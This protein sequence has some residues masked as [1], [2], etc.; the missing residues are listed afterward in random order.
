MSHLGNLASLKIE[1]EEYTKRDKVYEKK[2]KVGKM[3]HQLLME[4]RERHKFGS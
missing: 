4:V 2:K 3:E 1:R